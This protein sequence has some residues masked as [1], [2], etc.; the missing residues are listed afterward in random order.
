MILHCGALHVVLLQAQLGGSWHDILQTIREKL[1]EENA[2]DDT[3]DTIHGWRLE[4]H[5]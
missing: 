3:I 1:E 5:K 4:D 2:N